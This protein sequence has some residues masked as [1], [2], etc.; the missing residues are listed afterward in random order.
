MFRFPTF[1]CMFGELNDSSY[2]R[3]TRKT[4]KKTKVSANLRQEIWSVNN[5]GLNIFMNCQGFIGN[6][7]QDSVVFNGISNFFIKSHKIIDMMSVNFSLICCQVARQRTLLQPKCI[8]R[9]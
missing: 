1:Q 7:K 9:R 2:N 4:K 3:Q 8:S 5:Q 6:A